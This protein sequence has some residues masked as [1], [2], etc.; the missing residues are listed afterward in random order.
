M[1]RTIAA[2]FHE[3]ATRGAD[4]PALLYKS[5][6]SYVPVTWRQYR[7]KVEHLANWLMSIGL[8][9]GDRVALLCET[10]YEWVIADMAIHQAALVNVPIYP[11]LMPRQAAYILQDSGSKAVIVSGRKLLDKVMDVVEDCPDLREIVMIGNDA[12][13]DSG[14]TV[15]R[16]DDCIAKGGSVDAEMAPQ[17]AA[18][19]AEADPDGMCSIIYTSGTTGNPKGVMLSHENFLSNAGAVIPLA[20]ISPEDTSISFLPL[21]HVLERCMYY[22]ITMAGATIGYAESIDTVAANLMELRPTLMATVP[23]LLEKVYGRI[24]DGVAQGSPLKQKL[25]T[26]ALGVGRRHRLENKPEPMQYAVA[27]KLVFSKIRARLGGRMRMIVCGGAPMVKAIGEFFHIA[28]LAVCEGYGLTETSPVISLNLPGKV[29]FGTVGFVLPG[30]SVKIA[31]LGEICVKGPNIMLGYYQL[32]E[33]NA[34]VFDADG[35]F[36]TGDVGEMDAD[37]YLRIT[38]RI[39]ELIVLSNGKNVAPQPLENHLK[40]SPYIEQA[41]VI[42]DNRKFCTCLIVPNYEKLQAFA[43]SQGIPTGKSDLIDNNRVHALLREEIDRTTKDF[44]QYERVK[45]FA[46]LADEWT[47]ETGELTP[48]LKCKRKII[49]KNYAEK[50]DAMYTDAELAPV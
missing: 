32:P 36:H 9:A 34:D 5:N 30:V 8:Q 3:V 25:F 37:G 41:M 29:R 28:G 49:L 18:R 6:G 42:G 23:R 44:A 12:L 26:W 13:P 39:K 1:K 27:D 38:D 24:N 15:H 10:R 20:G 43:L 19:Q 48:T 45:K 14:R 17:R 2:M 21:S 35:W 50:V 40:T 31:E 33:A 7:Q 47:V 22:G 16:W 4:R 46:L 11:T